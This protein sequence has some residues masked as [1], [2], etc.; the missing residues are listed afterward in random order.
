MTGLYAITDG[1]GTAIA[2]AFTAIGAVL[3][4]L[5]VYR[6][7]GKGADEAAVKI[8][9]KLRNGTGEFLAAQVMSALH[10]QLSEIRSD[11]GHLHER[12]AITERGLT[13][14]PKLTDSVAEMST[15]LEELNRLHTEPKT[16]AAK[17][18]RA[19]KAAKATK[20]GTT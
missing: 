3:T 7:R 16:P 9:Q 13:E 10:P 20:K 19:V 14:I 5:I 12:M 4:A 8:D 6:S 11:L 15:R 17:R 1:A 18:A 2:A